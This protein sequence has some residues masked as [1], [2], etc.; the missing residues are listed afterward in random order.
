MDGAVIRSIVRA[1]RTEIG[2]RLET[3]SSILLFV[4]TTPCGRESLRYPCHLL[5]APV[6]STHL[7]HL[8]PIPL[9]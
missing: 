1:K 6:S 4:P 8:D 5:T 3:V 7:M 2:G 9:V